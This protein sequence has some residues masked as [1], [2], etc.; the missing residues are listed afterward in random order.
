M[1]KGICIHALSVLAF[2][3]PLGLSIYL[4]HLST[5]YYLSSV[6]QYMQEL[7][8]TYWFTHTQNLIRPSLCK[9]NLTTTFKGSANTSR[10]LVPLESLYRLVLPAK[11]RELSFQGRQ[12]H[13]EGQEV[14]TLT[15]H[16]NCFKKL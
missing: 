10:P 4:Y 9:Q 8:T 2:C 16:E 14:L 12:G 6:R 13:T 3:L 1:G 5:F 15:A 11:F 7:S